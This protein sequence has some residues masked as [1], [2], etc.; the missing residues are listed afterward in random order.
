MKLVL[1]SICRRE[2]TVVESK[3]EGIGFGMLIP[4]FFVTTGVTFD[5]AALL[6]SP[7]ALALVPVGLAGFPLVRG[8][9]VML[10]HRRSCRVTS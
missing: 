3:L 8:V 5:V 2:A 10:A 4:F 1:A 6:G 7:A 9:P